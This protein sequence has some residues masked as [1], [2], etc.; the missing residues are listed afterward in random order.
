MWRMDG[1]LALILEDKSKMFIKDGRVE[2]WL[3]VVFLAPAHSI[4]IH[5]RGGMVCKHNTGDSKSC[6]IPFT[7]RGWVNEAVM[8]WLFFLLPQ[9]A[10]RSVG[11]LSFQQ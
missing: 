4:L 2:A 7:K 9:E 8:L 3:V 10:E 11:D 6:V 1:L 5:F